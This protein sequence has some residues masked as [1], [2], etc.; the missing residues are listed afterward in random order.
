M[1]FGWF[2]VIL[3]VDLHPSPVKT[4]KYSIHV[5]G[6]R[7]ETTPGIGFLMLAM[8]RTNIFFHLNAFEI[9]KSLVYRDSL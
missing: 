8:H 1:V 5:R 7:K 6:H 2:Y 3:A 4:F 9:L